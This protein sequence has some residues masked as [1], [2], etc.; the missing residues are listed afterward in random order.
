MNEYYV[1][2][3]IDYT[4]LAHPERGMR[5]R[6]CARTCRWAAAIRGR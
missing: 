1:S 3:Y 2:H 6:R 4:P 5:A